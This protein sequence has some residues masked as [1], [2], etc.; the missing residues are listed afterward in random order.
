[1]TQRSFGLEPILRIL[2]FLAAALDEEF[3]GQ[4]RDFLMRGL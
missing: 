4:A 1:L 2:A 3:A